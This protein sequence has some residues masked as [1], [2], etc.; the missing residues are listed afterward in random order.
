MPLLGKNQDTAG[1]YALPIL[2]ALLAALILLE[3]TGVIDVISGFG[4]A[5]GGTSGGQLPV[6]E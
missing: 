2:L 1:A 4:P 3:L 5:T 6:Y